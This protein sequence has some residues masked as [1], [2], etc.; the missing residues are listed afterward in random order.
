MAVVRVALRI[1]GHVQGVGYRYGAQRQAIRLGLSGFVRNLGDGS[2][3]L[4]AEGEDEKIAEMIAW[5]RRGPAGAGVTRI[6]ESRSA[7]TGERRT[8]A[9]EP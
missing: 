8:F 5:C 2:V 9:I 4:V 1:H 3:E 7:P 6:D